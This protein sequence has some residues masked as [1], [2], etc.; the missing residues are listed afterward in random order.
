MDVW[1]SEIE[2]YNSR[3]P[4]ALAPEKAT[5]RTSSESLREGILGKDND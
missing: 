3:N 5:A 4:V 1:D 2:Q